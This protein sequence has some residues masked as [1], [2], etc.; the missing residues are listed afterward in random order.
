M[1]HSCYL[2]LLFLSVNYCYG[3]KKNDLH[4]DM[5]I[6]DH[7]YCPDAVKQFPPI[8]L[9]SWNKTPVINGRLPTWEE[10][11]RGISITYIDKK[12]NPDLRD[13]KAYK[14]I[15]PKLAS[16][17]NPETHKSETVVVIQMIQFSQFVYVGY[18]F[19]TGGVGS[20]TLSKCHFLTDDEV[21][22]AIR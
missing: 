19:L 5:S 9:K 22:K 13:A 14:I 12:V 10:T 16:I 15:L 2:I 20:C 6:I 1:K 21:K 18:R 8:N 11:E 3:Q 4:V 17:I 7:Q